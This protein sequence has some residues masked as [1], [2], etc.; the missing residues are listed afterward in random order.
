M[1]SHFYFYLRN[2]NVKRASM[3]F[4]IAA[5]AYTYAKRTLISI[6][7]TIEPAFFLLSHINASPGMC[8]Q[9]NP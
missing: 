2:I 8:P 4:K 9:I 6:L 5:A 1:S 3:P 7:T